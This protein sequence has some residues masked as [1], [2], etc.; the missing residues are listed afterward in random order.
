MTKIGLNEAV[1]HEQGFP[2]IRS[3]GWL[4]QAAKIN[5]PPIRPRPSLSRSISPHT[6]GVCLP[7]Q[8]RQT[9]S[10]LETALNNKAPQQEQQ[11]PPET[12]LYFSATPHLSDGHAIND[13][14][15]G[16]GGGGRRRYSSAS[17]GG[18]ESPLGTVQESGRRRSRSPTDAEA[19]AAAA[20]ASGAAAAAATAWGRYHGTSVGG[21]ED[22]TTFFPEG[23]IASSES[24]YRQHED[25]DG[26][27]EGPAPWSPGRRVS[28][29]EDG[30]RRGG[31]R[32]VIA[33][34]NRSLG[35]G[36]GGRDVVVAILSSS[37]P[38]L[39]GPGSTKTVVHH[40][41]RWRRRWQR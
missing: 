12:D 2:S 14:N 22:S 23:D 10:S 26:L 11:Y 21:R 15:S 41:R 24:F 20:G 34:R 36:G 9:I 5:H 3:L 13:F 29:W 1:K 31:A 32:A 19:A 39:P 17:R 8:M 28:A 16:G 7:Q 38:S 30:G 40:C 35:G 37:R 25:D 6:M 33:A 18:G 27:E 4:R